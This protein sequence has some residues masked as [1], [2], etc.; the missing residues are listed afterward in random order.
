MVI[1]IIDCLQVARE[2]GLPQCLCT[3]CINTLEISYTFCTQALKV[4]VELRK[5]FLLNSSVKDEPSEL[6]TEDDDYTCDI[7]LD[8]FKTEEHAKVETKSVYKCYLCSKQFKSKKNYLQHC[9]SVES[10]LRCPECKKPFCKQ[11]S[12]D[13]HISL[14]HSM[15]TDF[16]ADCNETLEGNEVKQEVKIELDGND[17]IVCSV[18]NLTFE[19]R[20]AL[21]GHKKKHNH[22]GG[23]YKCDECSK[24][25]KSKTLMLR[26]MKLHM[27]ERPYSCDQCDKT[28]CR[29][30][31][32]KEHLRRHSGIKNNICSYCNKGWFLFFFVL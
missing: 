29:A 9:A 15:L 4:D 14:E 17:R 16:F 10:K 6:K 23:Q 13:L 8:Y 20:K 28:Y 3:S 22:G 18:C 27:K 1:V 11:K 32:L 31:Q 24:S 2:D 25:F 12:L 5:L 30:D 21:A 26:H 19:S 7:D